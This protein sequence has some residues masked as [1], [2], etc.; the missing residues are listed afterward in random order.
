MTLGIDRIPPVAHEAVLA[1]T[2]TRSIDSDYGVDAARMFQSVCWGKDLTIRTLAPDDNGKMAVTVTPSGMD[3]T[4]N[5]QLILEGLARSGKSMAIQILVGRMASSSVSVT[6]QLGADLNTAEDVAR[7]SRS[8][9][10]RYG[11]I[12]DEDPDEL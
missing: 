8:G 1:L 3:D 9:M 4:M 6:T 2:T 11:D 10:W 5:A 7:K 12:G